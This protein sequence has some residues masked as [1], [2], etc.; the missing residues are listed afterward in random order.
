MASPAI[1]TEH[2]WLVATAEGY[3]PALFGEKIGTLA[4]F[5]GEAGKIED[6]K[7]GRIVGDSSCPQ[8]V[9]DYHDWLKNW[10]IDN[11]VHLRTTNAGERVVSE[12]VILM[13]SADGRKIEWP[14]ATFACKTDNADGCDLYIYYTG[15]P[16]LQK[17]TKRPVIFEAPQIDTEPSDLLK[18]YHNCLTTGDIDGLPKVMAWD[19]YIH[20]SSGPPYTHLGMTA[21]QQY[22]RG[23]FVNGAPMMRT[24]RLTSDGRCT[25]IEFAVVGWNGQLW[26]ESDHQS[27]AG[28]WQVNEDNMMSGVRV[29]DDIEF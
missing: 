8:F 19:A 12:D 13:T 5:I 16:I 22:F 28:V 15:W 11:V 24:E 21:V 4:S 18:Q 20:E 26:P 7:F 3:V 14:F 27:G 2:N 10:S 9:S 1:I 23:L 25:W 29:Y 17:H 6:H